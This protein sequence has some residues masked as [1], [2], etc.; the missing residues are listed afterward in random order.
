MADALPPSAIGQQSVGVDLHQTLW[1]DVQAKPAHELIQSPPRGFFTPAGLLVP[2]S[3]S[4]PLPRGFGT[5]SAKVITLH[6]G[7][8]EAW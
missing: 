6:C 8:A 7:L 2:R 5:S 3:L 4:D 1:Q